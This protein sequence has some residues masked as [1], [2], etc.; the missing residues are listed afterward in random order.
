MRRAL[1]ALV[2][3][4]LLSPLAAQAQRPDP[5]KAELDQLLTALATA[6]SDETAALMER[7]V[8]QLWLQSG[9]P[10]VA[11]LLSHG[12][13]NLSTGAPDD[14]VSDFDAAVVLAPDCAEAYARRAAGRY[15]AGD[16][17]GALRDIQEALKREPRHFAALH[18]LSVIAENQG[19]LPGA[20]AAWKQVLALDPHT[21]GAQERLKQLT[22][23]VEGEES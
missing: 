4:V 19:N 1:P 16:V 23:K 3:A 9:G 10:T 17:A 13:R 2:L 7:R 14:A 20:L 22:R 8:M 5:R 12:A 15:E 21:E 11:M 6:P 18:T